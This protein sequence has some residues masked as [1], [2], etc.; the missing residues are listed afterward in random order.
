MY[1]WYCPKC[2][3]WIPIELVQVAKPVGETFIGV[4]C[5]KCKT[6]L[7]DCKGDDCEGCEDRYLCITQSEATTEITLDN[8]NK[9]LI[10]TSAPQK[11]NEIEEKIGGI[12]SYT[13]NINT[14]LDEEFC[15]YPNR[16]DCNYSWMRANYRG[17]AY[18]RC[19]YMQYHNGWLCTVGARRR[20]II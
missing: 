11:S 15:L 13:G 16:D 12:R 9:N 8:V 4:I 10:K 1:G 19:M 7:Q 3:T 17:E 20:G 2:K 5:I 14:K 18:Q 6:E